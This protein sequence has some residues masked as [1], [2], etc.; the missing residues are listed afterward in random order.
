VCHTCLCLQYIKE[1]IYEEIGNNYR[2]F[3]K[4]RHAA[5][6]GNMIVLGAIL[7]FSVSAFKDAK[8]LMWIIPLV[9]SPVGLLLWI[10]DKRNRSL[11]HI[12][13]RAGKEIEDSEGVSGF[14]SKLISEG[15]ALPKDKSAYSQL[16]Q[17]LA[18]ELFFFGSSIMLI[19][20]SLFFYIKWGG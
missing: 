6:A 8:E 4:W 15:V 16:T 13:N 9:A 1:K 18:L 7:S 11:Y 10:I 12:V 14:Y 17:S 5:F 2:F 20:L 3:L 19:L